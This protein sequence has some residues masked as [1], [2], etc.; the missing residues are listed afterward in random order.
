MA[1]QDFDGEAYIAFDDNQ[2]RHRKAHNT[3]PPLVRILRRQK[4]EHL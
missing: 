2:L 1:T 3:G 4:R